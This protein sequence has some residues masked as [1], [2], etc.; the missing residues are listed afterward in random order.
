M[1]A[2]LCGDFN[3]IDVARMLAEVQRVLKE[4]GFYIVISYGQPSTRLFHFDR[5][6]L[7]FVCAT[8]ELP[9]RDKSEEES[10]N[11]YAYVL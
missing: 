9:I 8:L 2:L 3:F 5:A 7:D 6:H 1:D 4:G 11:H 10:G